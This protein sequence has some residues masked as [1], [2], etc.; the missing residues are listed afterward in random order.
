MSDAD[1]DAVFQKSTAASTIQITDAVNGEAQ[2]VVQP[3]NTS[4]LA[5]VTHKLVYD[6]QLTSGASVHTLDSGQFVV[7]AD[8]TVTT[9]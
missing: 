3:A 4:G 1:G 5:A 7:E 6:L 2:I 8:V 9:S